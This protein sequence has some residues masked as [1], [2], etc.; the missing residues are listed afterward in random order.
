M[1]DQDCYLMQGMIPL[2]QRMRMVTG[3]PGLPTVQ[4]CLA[5]TRRPGKYSHIRRVTLL[6]D[7]MERGEPYGKI[8]P[9]IKEAIE[10]GLEELKPG[11]LKAVYNVF[12]DVSKDFDLMFVV[13]ALP[14]AQRD[15]LR[16]R[17]MDYVYEAQKTIDGQLTQ[18]FA[19]ATK[20]LA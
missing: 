19:K 4:P 20:G 14:N 13:E 7:T 15:A 12:K 10:S 17:I 3:N 2:Y 9:G 16:Q 8:L 1:E 18:E 6:K 11:L 5:L